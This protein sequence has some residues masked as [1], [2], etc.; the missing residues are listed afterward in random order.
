MKK[1]HLRAAAA[2]RRTQYAHKPYA[3]LSHKTRALLMKKWNLRAAAGM[4]L[5]AVRGGVPP[6]PVRAQTI[7]KSK[8]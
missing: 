6:H 2:C 3:N 8:P 1:P 5:Q 4:R 7:C